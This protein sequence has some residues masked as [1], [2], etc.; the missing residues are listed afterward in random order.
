M[1]TRQQFLTVT[2]DVASIE[3]K[4]VFRHLVTGREQKMIELEK[5]IELF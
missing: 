2:F 5:I 4:I 3:G 1:T